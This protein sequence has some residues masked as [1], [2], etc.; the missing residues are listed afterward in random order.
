L[1]RAANNHH[2]SLVGKKKESFRS[3]QISTDEVFGSLD[4]PGTFNAIT[5]YNPRI[6][7]S[8]SKAA[9]DHLVKVWFHTFELQVITT[10]CINNYGP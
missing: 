10:N 2:H 8:A 4:K 1:L 3:H 6:P 7:Y 9:S 5:P